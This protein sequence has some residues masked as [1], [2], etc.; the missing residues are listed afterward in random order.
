MS[1]KANKTSQ[2][3]TNVRP[4]RSRGPKTT[5][6][7][8][9]AMVEWLEVKQNFNLL[10]GAATSTMKTGTVA[11][12]KL[13][14]KSAYESIADF[15]NQKCSTN[16]TVSNAEFRVKNYIK[17]YKLTKRA[18]LN[19]GGEKYNLGPKDFKKGILTIEQKL[20]ADCP[21]FK[22]MDVLFGGRQNITPA[23]VLT[24]AKRSAS[25]ISA[26]KE[27]AEGGELSSDD[28]GSAEEEE[29]ES[30]DKE[31]V[32]ED[33]GDV[34]DD[35]DNNDVIEALTSLYSSCH[36]NNNDD[37]FEKQ[38]T[39]TCS[40][41]SGVSSLSNPLEAENDTKNDPWEE[42]KKIPE[43][44][45]KIAEIKNNVAAGNKGKK[46]FT[47]TYAETQLKKIELDREKFLFEKEN[48]GIKREDDNAHATAKLAQE[49]KN[50]ILTEMLRKGATA[51]EIKEY[52]N[53]LV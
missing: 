29:S 40:S 17:V 30:G 43:L 53:A 42:K 35:D 7:Q 9:A 38:H 19:P 23:C 20:E 45:A 34:E 16:W 4:K 10:V 13:T 2:I 11:G 5:W 25:H 12:A 37:A 41:S 22:R 44:T 31:D 21:N 6:I 3:Q 36:D 32:E 48:V 33:V 47:T 27:A 52:I 50:V 26:E 15:V 39:V 51:Q 46:D 14:K 28:E 18:Q 24:G 1:N 49:T 8:Y